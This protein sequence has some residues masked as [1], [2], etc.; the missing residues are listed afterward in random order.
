MLGVKPVYRKRGLKTWKGRKYY[1]RSKKERNSILTCDDIDAV[2]P[3][4]I[5]V[6]RYVTFPSLAA[7]P[8]VT[9]GQAYLLNPIVKGTSR[10][11]RIGNRVIIDTVECNVKFHM[12][13]NSTSY[14]P[15]AIFVRV[16]IIWDRECG[17]VPTFEQLFGRAAEA[18]YGAGSGVDYN[19]S[20][21]MVRNPDFQ[22][23]YLT[24]AEECVK[25]SP[26]VD[27]AAGSGTIGYAVRD[28]GYVKI[29]RKINKTS[30]FNAD[31]S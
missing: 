21:V 1:S 25:I 18:D 29:F 31:V 16:L 3:T 10:A 24:I 17:S 23:R 30:I 9:R 14:S 7:T 6:D 20:V 8:C 2:G 19:N 28:G 22:N 15:D 4:S 11:N 5:N 12:S 27:N 13:P 26:Q